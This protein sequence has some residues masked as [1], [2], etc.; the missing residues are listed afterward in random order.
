MNKTVTAKTIHKLSLHQTPEH[1]ELV[2]MEIQVTGETAHYGVALSQL[3][4]LAENLLKQIEK[5]EAG[6]AKPN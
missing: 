2:V 6:A 1:P 4:Q 5:L 3:R